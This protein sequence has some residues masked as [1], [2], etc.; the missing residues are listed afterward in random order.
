MM[1]IM[2][3]TIMVMKIFYSV[4]YSQGYFAYVEKQK[5]TETIPSDNN[6]EDDFKK[7]WTF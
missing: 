3:Q 5:Q 2:M 4:P 1:S 7:I 6:K